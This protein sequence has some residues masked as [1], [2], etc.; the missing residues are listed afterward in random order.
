VAKY[1]KTTL[2]DII[3]PRRLVIEGLKMDVLLT[4]NGN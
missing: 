3:D 1:L 4:S 2:L